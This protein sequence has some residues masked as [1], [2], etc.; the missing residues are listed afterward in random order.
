MFLAWVYVSKRC[1]MLFQLRRWSLLVFVAIFAADF[2]FDDL[3]ESDV[4]G[5]H[6]VVSLDERS[7]SEVQLLYTAGNKIDKN[8]WFRNY[9]GCL[10]D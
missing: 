1:P 10:Y 5:A 2:A 6:A 9:F 4:G 7:P 8:R 3:S